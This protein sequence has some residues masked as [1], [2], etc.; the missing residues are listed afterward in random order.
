MI[1]KINFLCVSASLRENKKKLNPILLI[2]FI[3]S[4]LVSSLFAQTIPTGGESVLAEEVLPRFSL[5]G[6]YGSGQV[7]DV[8]GQSFSQAIQ[9]QTISKPPNDYNFQLNTRTFASI[10]QNDVLLGVVWARTVQASVETGGAKVTFIFERSGDPY[11]KSADHTMRPAGGDWQVFYIPF[12]SAETYGPGEAQLNLKCGYD[13]QTVE[14]GGI[15]LLNYRNTLGLDELPYTPISYA[16]MEPGAPWRAEAQARIEQYRKADISVTVVDASGVPVPGA[17]VGLRLTRHAFGFGSAVVCSR[18]MDPGSADPAQYRQWIDSLFSRVVIENELKWPMWEQQYRRQTTL[19]GLQWLRDRG[20]EIR[21]HCL[22]WPNWIYLPGDLQGLQS[23][24]AA[25]RQ[26][27]NDHITDE[28]GT[29]QGQLLDWDVINEPYTNHVLMDTLGDGEMAEWFRMARR[30]DSSVKLYINDYSILAGGG[31]DNAHQDHY[32][33]TIQSL[34]SSGA[35][36]DGLGLQSHF[37]ADLTSPQRLWQILE[38][39]DSLGL[40]MQ[41]TEFDV[42]ITDQ[43]VQAAYTRDF[44]TMLFSHPSVTGILMWGFWAGAHWRPDCALFDLDWTMREHGR[45]WI[46]LVHG[47]WSTKVSGATDDQGVYQARGFL[48]DY[49]LAIRVG[50]SLWTED[51]Q[52]PSSGAVITSTLGAGYVNVVPGD[53]PSVGKSIF[54]LEQGGRYQ[55]DRPFAIYDMTGKRLPVMYVSGRYAAEGLGQGM[56]VV[57]EVGPRQL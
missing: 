1:S 38:R 50:D 48:G 12:V 22:V 44:M 36:I 23:D 10:S 32:Y 51:F 41:V 16:G 15:Q 8:T 40:E 57:K 33:N 55:S 28:V 53:R 7:V 13:P 21:G 26:R 9:V 56:Y 52:L 17:Q 24:T 46:D 45:A 29:L 2:T 14:V 35:P 6:S 20:I 27:I 5:Q 31:D 49:Q 19:D 43:E 18:I 25:L 42:N 11:T 34:I 37:G 39:F 30:S 4:A 3:A 47:Q 54:V